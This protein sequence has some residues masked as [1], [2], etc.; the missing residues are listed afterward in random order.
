MT[1][2]LTLLR[3]LLVPA[4]IV[5]VFGS[6]HQVFVTQ[7]SALAPASAEGAEGDPGARAH[8]EW[9][10]LH[11]PATGVIPSNIR[12]KELAYAAKL[13]AREQGSR[14]GGSANGAAKAQSTVWSWRGPTNVGGRT[15]ALASDVHNANV[16]LAGGVSGGMWR[17]MDAGASW[18]RATT[19]TQLPS[20]SCISQDPRAGHAG[21]WYYGTG[22][23]L[24]NSANGG[25]TNA[26][27]GGDGIFKSTD[28]GASW[29]LLSSTSVNTPESFTSPFNYIWNV[30]VDPSSPSND[31]VYA[32]CFGVI[33][34]TTDGGATWSQVLGSFPGS[35]YSAETDVQ[36]TTGGVLYAAGSF[37][38]GSDMSGIWR[39]TDA[40]GT[41]TSIIPASFPTDFGRIVIGIAPSNQNIVYFLV[42]GANGTNGTDQINGCQFWKYTYLSGDGSGAGGSW[43]N[44]GGNLPNET[45]LS[46]NAVFDTQR[47]YD[48]LVRVK[49]DDANFVLVGGTNLYRSTD[50]F[51]TTSNWKRVGGY[52]LPSTYN[53][54]T[55]H[56][57]DQHSGAF[58]TGSNISFISGH[59]EGISRTS[60]I[61]AGTVSWSS[62]NHGYGTTQFYSVA[63]DHGTSGNAIV[64]GGMQ[65]EGSWFTNSSSGSALWVSLFGGDGTTCAIANGRTSY[66][67]S[68]QNALT[69][70]IL[71]DANGAWSQF[72]RV[73]P[74]GGSGYLFVNPF[75]LD[76]SNTN[77]MYFAGGS[78]LWCN[79]DLTGI[80][81][82]TTTPPST[83]WTDLTAAGISSGVITA[84]GVSKSTPS[85]RLYYGS[86][87][88]QLWRLDNATSATGSTAATD[89]WTGMGFPSGAYVSSIAVDPTNGD[90]VL[91]AFSNYSVLSM[92]YTTDAGTT[93]GAVS[94]N[95]EENTDGS[96]SGPSVRWASI[97]P[98]GGSTY[99]YAGTSTGLYSTQ[100]LSGMAT[101]WVQEGAS[102][103]GNVVVDAIDTRSS[104]GLVVVGTHGNGAF[105]GTASPNAVV[106]PREGPLKAALLANYPNPFN[107]STTIRFRL[108][109]SAS[110]RLKIYAVDG[111]EVATLVDGHMTQGEHGVVWSPGNLASGVYLCRLEA[112]TS[113]GAQGTSFVDSRKVVLLK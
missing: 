92:F 97:L 104:D 11:D 96:G 50:G 102:T 12:T 39:S 72:A 2:G 63:V 70:R 100:A 48:M 9:M 108:S 56:H 6:G 59:D 7:R 40:G 78:H 107:P 86:S 25:G 45:G 38:S 22:E 62:L 66:Y 68:A 21:T 73:D 37:A 81:L 18:T 98:Y 29:V 46:G 4:V 54:Y 60:D 51:A 109:S 8:W 30:A 103:I 76:P 55:N 35:G 95:L 31:V 101:V 112:R 19:P 41:W 77:V 5:F 67:V 32:A 17:S 26:F 3:V 13:P 27:Y 87:D 34:Q 64:I 110:V 33:E 58:V 80:A 49:P 16:M 10:R 1:R 105:S 99:Y 43:V 93:W 57:P 23:Y 75:A 106:E 89:V 52:A 44:R 74:Q 82:S 71:V 28:N 79:S 47:G 24:G 83:N 42:E 113:E 69:Y 65:D 53:W 84:L 111:R 15:R 94:G 61:T 91:V 14:T 88:G 85:N 20:V 90:N 36:I